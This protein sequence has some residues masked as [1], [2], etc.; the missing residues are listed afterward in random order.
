MQAVPCRVN[1]KTA[2]V[3]KFVRSNKNAVTH[4]KKITADFI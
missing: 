4:L 3:A 2:K 1:F